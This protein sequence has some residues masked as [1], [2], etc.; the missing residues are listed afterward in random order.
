MR[1]GEVVHVNKV[2][3]TRPIRGVVIVAEHLKTVTAKRRIDGP[4]NQVDFRCVVFSQFTV[5]I[6]PCG[7]E[8][9]QRNRPEPVCG[10]VMR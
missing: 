2:A 6:R 3:K 1:R 9:A 5:R 10:F 7:I 4:R 8:I